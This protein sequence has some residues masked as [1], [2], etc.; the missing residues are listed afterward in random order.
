MHFSFHTEKK[1]PDNFREKIS[2][3]YDYLFMTKYYCNNVHMEMIKFTFT[4]YNLTNV[5][6][7]MNDE[8]SIL[9]Y[10]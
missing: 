6:N 7:N 2:T 5:E 3:I 1:K 4:D 8:D 9:I 10:R